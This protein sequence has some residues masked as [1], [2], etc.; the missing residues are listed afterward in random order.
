[1]PRHRHSRFSRDGAGKSY[2]AGKLVEE[3]LRFGAPTIVL[4]PV[5]TWYGLRLRD[6]HLLQDAEPLRRPHDHRA[7]W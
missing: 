4:D 5:G 7:H 6:P 2:A 1:M 3:L